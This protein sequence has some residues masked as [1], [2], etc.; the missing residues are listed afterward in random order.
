MEVNP[1]LELLAKIRH[2]LAQR[3]TLTLATVDEEGQPHAAALF[4][5]EAEDHTF[6]FLSGLKSRHSL[7][8]AHNGLAAVTVQGETWNWREIAG[9]QMRGTVTLIPAGTP[10]ERTWEIYKAK[11]PFVSEFETEVSRSEFYRFQPHWIRLIDNSLRFG[12]REEMDLR[13]SEGA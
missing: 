4:F 12:Y 2:F 6:I 10:R 1:Q 13:P 3:S 9:V 5:A 8:V 7:N 11:F